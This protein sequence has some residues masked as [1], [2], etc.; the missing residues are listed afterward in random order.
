[1]AELIF[2]LGGALLARAA[3]PQLGLLALL[4]AAVPGG[5]AWFLTRDPLLAAQMQRFDTAMIAETGV[6]A[7]GWALLLVC[8]LAASTAFILGISLAAL[9]APR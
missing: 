7:E 6:A 2:A 4:A 1:M 5:L 8:V 9:R 3:A